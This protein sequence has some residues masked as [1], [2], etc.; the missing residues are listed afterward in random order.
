MFI[1]WL[2]VLTVVLAPPLLCAGP[3]GR[4]TRTR[5]AARRASFVRTSRRHANS[6]DVGAALAREGLDAEKTR[7]AVQLAAA[8][9][10]AP[11]TMWGWI[12]LHGVAA[13]SMVEECGGTAVAEPVSEAPQQFDDRVELDSSEELVADGRTRVRLGDN[14]VRRTTAA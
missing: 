3:A 5:A 12:D 6:G 11:F 4:Q 1:L 2:T 13:L 7:A 14:V 9:G 8:K 10:I